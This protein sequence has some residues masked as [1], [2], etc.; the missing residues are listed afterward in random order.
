VTAPLRSIQPYAASFDRQWSIGS[1]TSLVRDAAGAAWV[2]PATDGVVRPAS[3]SEADETALWR[4]AQR[5]RQDEPSTDQVAREAS[6]RSGL[7]LASSPWH[8][9]P[10][11]ALAGNFLH[12]LLE[13]LA[14]EGFAL[15]DNPSLQQALLRR[16]ER[17]AWG[18]RADEVL[19]WLTHLCQQPLPPLQTALDSLRIRVAEL[20]FWIPS[21]GLQSGR[22]DA[23]C[24]KTWFPGQ[25]RPALVQRQLQ[26]LM[27]GFADLVFEHQGR[28]WVLDYK[29][30][31]LGDDDQAYTPAAM[32]AAVLE[33]RY[34]VQA[35]L[36]LLPLHRLL[37]WRLG[38]AYKPQQHLGGAIYFF[39]RGI[40]A[41]SAG[42]LHLP[43]SMDLLNGLEAMLDDESGCQEQ[44]A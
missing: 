41:P 12:N 44:G 27:M 43:P 13:W 39:I 24:A 8:A 29:S 28:Y 16:C 3:T 10:R 7:S 18:H 35:A 9:F 23:L 30:N 4:A 42:C 20:E 17:A 6:S 21:N 1:Y 5:L 11:G 37:R 33:H 14:G 38:A 26:G 2:P 15:R 31:A 34:D 32:Q 36:Y 19:Q 40:H 25:A 22:L